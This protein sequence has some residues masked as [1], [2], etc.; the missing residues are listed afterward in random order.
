MD[1]FYKGLIRKYTIAFGKLL[2]DFYIHRDDVYGVTQQEIRVPLTYASKEKFITVYKQENRQDTIRPPS[3]LLP[4][5]SYVLTSIEYDEE[6]K[7]NQMLVY[8]NKYSQKDT[9]G[10]FTF[11][12]IPY[13]FGFSVS[14]WTNIVFSLPE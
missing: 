7:T 12:P 13:N 10:D 9:N 5:M 3:I 2:T 11:N 1:Y 14:I 6:R 4:R 8:S